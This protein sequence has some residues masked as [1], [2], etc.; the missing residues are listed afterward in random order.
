MFTAVP[1]RRSK[2]FLQFVRSRLLQRGRE[3][4]REKERER[5]RDKEKL[6]EDEENGIFILLKF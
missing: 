2:F 3:R 1:L 5:E 4:G 6:E